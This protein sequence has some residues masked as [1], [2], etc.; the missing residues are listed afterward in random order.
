[1][2][3]SAAA[4][5]RL[6]IL[7]GWKESLTTGREEFEVHEIAPDDC[8]LS[9]LAVFLAPGNRRTRTSTGRSGRTGQ[10]NLQF[11][12]GLY[13]AFHGLCSGL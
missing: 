10:Y 12:A 5:E 13:L 4:A 2:R 3:P 6:R 9:S 7:S 11:D 8:A 1:M